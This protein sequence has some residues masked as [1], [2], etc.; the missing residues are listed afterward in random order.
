MAEFKPIV[1]AEYD[2]LS[3]PIVYEDV[4]RHGAAAAAANIKPRDLYMDDL[5]SYGWP[6]I[7]RG[8]VLA[9]GAYPAVVA[10]IYFVLGVAALVVGSLGMSARSPD[11][12]A[13]F[14]VLMGSLVFAAI[15]GLLGVIWS[16]VVTIVTLPVVH[17]VVWSMKLRPSLNWLGAF[18]GGLVAF[19][20]II[21]FTMQI[22]RMV[23][24]GEP[25]VGIVALLVGPALATVVGQIGGARGGMRGFELIAAKKMAPKIELLRLKFVMKSP[26]EDESIGATTTEDGA[27]GASRFQFRTVHLLWVGVWVSLLLTLIRLSG[28]PYEL[29]LPMLLGWGVFQSASLFLGMLLVR[30]FGPW[31]RGG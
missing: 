17:A 21:P 26:L 11:R 16:G 14:G 19:V 3:K 1:P 25:W 27:Q 6:S 13:V 7:A 23:D 12:V 10:A 20:A 4:M 24:D 5:V 15:A 8:I 2:E 28:I 29:I 30:R 9:G 18:S 31:W 22:P